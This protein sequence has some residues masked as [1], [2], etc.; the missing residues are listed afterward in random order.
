MLRG[1]REGEQLANGSDAFGATEQPAAAAL[2]APQLPLTV[3]GTG[4]A[5][6]AVV[7]AAIALVIFPT[8]SAT[9]TGQR[10]TGQSWAAAALVAAV[11]MLAVGIV[12]VLTWGR[13]LRSWRGERL[14][15]LHGEARLS[16]VA[17][18]LSYP[19]T[20]L[21][22]LGSLAGSA[23]AGWSAPSAVLLAVSLFFVIG[24]EVLAGVQY[25]RPGGPPGTLP[26]HLRRLVERSRQRED[27]FDE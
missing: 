5:L 13:A 24:A 1:M 14:Q 25:L 19:I 16:W 22:V 4:C 3:A 8:F 23:A 7:A 21:A 26:A 18:V 11:A 2:M 9:D 12:Q 20:L 15:D 17:H 10:S 27:E 6:V